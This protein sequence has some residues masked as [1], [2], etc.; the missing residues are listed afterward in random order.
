MATSVPKRAAGGG[1]GASGASMGGGS[2]AAP[3]NSG[4]V[5]TV[6]F[7]DDQDDSGK[8]PDRVVPLRYVFKRPEADGDEV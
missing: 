2:G 4:Y 5:C 1:G 3:L 8:V 6:Q 7:V